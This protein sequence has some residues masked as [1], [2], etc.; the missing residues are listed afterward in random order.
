RHFLDREAQGSTWRPGLAILYCELGARD[1]AS[2]LFERLALGGF[3]GIARDAIR[4]ASLAYL[5][6]VCVWLGDPHRAAT[7]FE[8]LLPYTGRNIV[9][10]AHTASFGAADRLLGMLAT[11]LQQW[12]V[13]QQHLEH[14]IAFDQRTGGRP[15]LAQS[16][17][18][19]ATMLMRRGNGG[20]HD[21]ARPLLQAALDETRKL[22]MRGLEETVLGLQRQAAA[23]HAQAPA[24]AGLSKRE[25]QVLR[26]VAAGKT[27]QEIATALFRSP[28]TIANHVRNILGKTQTANRTEASAFAARHG[29]LPPE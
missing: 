15:W 10:G 9:L 23:G 1:E 8:S 17:C 11:T 21:R 24:V 14:A 13:A 6:E 4:I 28:N 26:L 27:N 20:D 19:L 2:E 22:G 7:P 18:A 12:E 29:L 3:A 16:R 5:A 25:L